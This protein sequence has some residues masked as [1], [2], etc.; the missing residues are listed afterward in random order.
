MARV[1]VF[2]ALISSERAY[3]SRL[4]RQG[5]MASKQPGFKSTWTK[6]NINKLLVKLRKFGTVRRVIFLTS[7]DT[8]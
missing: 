6:N 4:H 5:R 8:I 1:L 2:N 3:L 7:G